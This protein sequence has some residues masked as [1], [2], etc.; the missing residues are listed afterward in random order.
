MELE[1]D[2]KIIMALSDAISTTVRKAM[3]YRRKLTEWAS[4]AAAIRGEPIGGT[5][6]EQDPGAVPPEVINAMVSLAVSAG[7]T[8]ESGWMLGAVGCTR[9][10][11]TVERGMVIVPALPTITLLTGMS[12]AST[13]R[14]LGHELGHVLLGHT[15][16][17][18]AESAAIMQERLDRLWRG[19]DVVE[20]LGDEVAVELGTAAVCRLAGI[21]TGRFSAEYVAERHAGISEASRWAALLSARALWHA[22]AP[23]VSGARLVMAG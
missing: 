17:S 1:Q 21:G 9:G 13:A 3:E 7:Y 5:S 23:A 2:P 15:G 16:T 12:D 20:D 11:A 14:V 4:M 22:I 10:Y 18:Y 19:D 6:A 8:V